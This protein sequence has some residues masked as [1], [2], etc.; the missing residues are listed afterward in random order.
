MCYTAKQTVK[1]Y[2]YPSRLFFTCYIA[3]QTVME[4]SCPSSLVFTSPVTVPTKQDTNS[5]IYLY[6]I[7]WTI[8]RKKENDEDILLVVY[9]HC[10]SYMNTANQVCQP[11]FKHVHMHSY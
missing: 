2:S 11:M 8:K 6:N 7:P 5:P 4:Y 10:T 1:D 9:F 3:N